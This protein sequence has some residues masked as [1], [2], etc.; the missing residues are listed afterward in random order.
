MRWDE[1]IGRRLKLRDLHILMAV[2]ERGTM[3]RAASSL[4]LSQP[5]VSRAVA[6]LEHT[7]GLR[8]LDRSRQ[9]SNPQ[10]TATHSSDA[11][12]LCSTSCGRV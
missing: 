7:L 12:W 2:V 1:R 3:A 6:D 9:G 10:L 5:A 11:G 4:A 8:L